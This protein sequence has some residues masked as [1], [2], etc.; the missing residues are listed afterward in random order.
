MQSN[1]PT[2]DGEKQK[3]QIGIEPPS[4]MDNIHCFLLLRDNNHHS[5]NHDPPHL[6]TISAQVTFFSFKWQPPQVPPS[7]PS[8]SSCQGQACWRSINVKYTTLTNQNAPA[9]IFGEHLCNQQRW[10]YPWKGYHDPHPLVPIYRS[11]MFSM[12]FLATLV[13][14]HF[15]PVSQ[16]LGR[17]VGDSFGLA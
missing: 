6:W 2:L 8:V 14:L 11:A 3:E 9:N 17:S 10:S 1:A 15:T 12:I 5:K 4:A 7:S 13:A 16:S